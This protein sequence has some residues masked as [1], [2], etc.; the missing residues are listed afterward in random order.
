[1]GKDTMGESYIMIKTDEKNYL[2]SYFS[3]ENQMKVIKSA[4]LSARGS[5]VRLF[6]RI[7]LEAVGNET[8]KNLDELETFLKCTFAEFDAEI[9]FKTLNLLCSCQFLQKIKSDDGRWELLT[10]AF[11]KACM[12]STL[13]P[14]SA[15]DIYNELDRA[16]K[17]LVS[18][19]TV[20]YKEKVSKIGF[21][22]FYLKKPNFS[23]YFTR[24]WIPICI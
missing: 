12:A 10:T 21:K 5:E 24:L 2:K 16:R 11:G 23:Q 1:M 3:N 8:V 18:Y 14:V 17:C 7:V 19:F 15:I 9:M 13:D 4:L 20:I 22:G 6:S